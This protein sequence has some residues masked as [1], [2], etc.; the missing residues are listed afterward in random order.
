MMLSKVNISSSWTLGSSKSRNYKRLLAEKRKILPWTVYLNSFL[1]RKENE[2]RKEVI[3]DFTLLRVK[4]ESCLSFHPCLQ[5]MKRQCWKFLEKVEATHFH[6]QKDSFI[7]ICDLLY[8]S[9]FYD[10]NLLLWLINWKW[11]MSLLINCLY[12]IDYCKRKDI[13]VCM[14]IKGKHS[15]IKIIFL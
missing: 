8:G 15:I 10:M 1:K 9:C 5:V 7:R 12:V 3:L 11:N 14:S 2:N 6:F 13:V 4:R